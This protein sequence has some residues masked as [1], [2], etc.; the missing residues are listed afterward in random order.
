MVG[1]AAPADAEAAHA[2]RLREHMRSTRTVAGSWF[3]SIGV[4]EFLDDVGHRGRRGDR[5]G[6]ALHAGAAGTHHGTG[7]DGR[8]AGE[9]VRP[10]GRDGVS[11][12]TGSRD[13]ATADTK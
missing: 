8:S 10:C 1:G 7:P 11:A 12:G 9:G 13:D 2:C 4:V 5:T 6:T 3:L